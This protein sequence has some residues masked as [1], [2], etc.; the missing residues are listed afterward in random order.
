MDDLSYDS[1]FEGNE[2]CKFKCK[3]MKCPNYVVCGKKAPEWLY[4]CHAG[5]CGMT[6]RNF[7]VVTRNNENN[8]ECPVCFDNPDLFVKFPTCE[9][10]FCGTCI[11]SLMFWDET[12]FHLSRVPYGCP[13]CPNGCENPI[14]G[15]QCYC[16][17]YDPVQ[18]QWEKD[19]PHLYKRWNDNEI[20]SIEQPDFSIGRC[21][22]CR[23]LLGWNDFAHRESN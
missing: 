18:E 10:Y 20:L 8:E 16:E 22:M 12:K 5:K 13:P 14:M 7:D 2:E 3:P 15:R 1:D 6:C 21:P 9:H 4:D 11:R 23:K 17:E 19:F